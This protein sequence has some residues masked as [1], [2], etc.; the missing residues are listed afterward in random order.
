MP[1]PLGYSAGNKAMAHIAQ[2]KLAEMTAE[3]AKKVKI[4][5]FYAHYKSTGK[6]YKVLGFVIIEATDEVG[7]LY[8]ARYGEKITFVRPLSSWLEEV[9]ADGQFVPRFSLSLR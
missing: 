5:G 7:V 8:Q 6:L 9:E 3:A 4:G 2:S 1:L